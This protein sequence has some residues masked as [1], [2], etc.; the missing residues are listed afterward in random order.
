MAFE[1]ATLSGDLPTTEKLFRIHPYQQQAEAEVLWSDGALIVLDRSLFYPES[2]GQ[3]WDEGWIS[4]QRVVD[5]QDKLGRRV[6]PS[7]AQLPVDVD[8]VVVH[9]L[10]APAAFRPGQ[11]VEMRL[12]WP[13][14]YANMRNHSACHFMFA[15]VQ[16]LF[17]SGTEVPSR[18]CHI[19]PD[20]SRMDFAV[21][22]TTEQTYEAEVR[23]NELIARGLQ[24]NMLA[25][26]DSVGIYNWSYNGLRI[27][28][29]G[30]HVR[31]AGELSS[32]ALKR[33]KKG[34]AL[35][36]IAASL[37]DGNEHA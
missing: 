37:R 34:A 33:T 3:E 11:K 20:G 9:R 4:G 12:D 23:A 30:T 13:R 35:T 15:A 31:S 2:G 1:C 21:N 26:D 28:C 36:R 14:R 8:T 24:I 6:T 22:L 10:A 7:H 27:S 16:A 32:I 25:D 19:H 5:V 17:P 18:G 29:G